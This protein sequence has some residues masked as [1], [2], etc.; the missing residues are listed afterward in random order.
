[1]SSA[2]QALVAAL[3]PKRKGQRKSRKTNDTFAGA[4]MKTTMSIATDPAFPSKVTA[5]A[6]ATSP[7]ET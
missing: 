4:H 3:I 1:M 2:L 6:G 5:A 7:A